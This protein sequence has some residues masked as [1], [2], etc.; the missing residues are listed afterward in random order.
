MIIVTGATG[1]LG[2]EILERLLER[3][4]AARVGVSVRNVEKATALQERG[5]R[6]RQGDFSDPA[7]L[8]HAFEGAAQVLII[9]SNSSGDAAVEQHRNAIE[10]AKA[11]GARRVLY[12][13]HMGSNPASAFA[14]MRDHAA[15]EAMLGKSG[16]AFTSLRNGFYADSA[17]M[18]MG[19]ALETGKIVAPGDGL[20]SWTAHPDLA[21]AAV[22]A[23]TDETRLDGITPPLT[24]SEALDLEGIAAIA[25]RLS[26]RQVT[27]VTVPD[28]Q[29]RENLISHGI[30]EARAQ[31]L[32]G[33]FAA[34]RKGEF[35]AVDPTLERLLGRRPIS[36]RDVLSARIKS[37]TI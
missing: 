33:L 9:S 24:A 22:I 19:Q 5:L 11:A 12:T 34:S 1:K 29:H 30:P 25:S 21:E 15:T 18:L 27:R 20:V 31:I 8:R 28:E 23:L 14:A 3:V 6:V 36:M 10:A 7:S 37:T 32:V 2:R 4:P 26:G 16:M 35:A 17:L 13:S